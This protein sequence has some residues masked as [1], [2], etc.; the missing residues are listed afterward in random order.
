MIKKIA[1]IGNGG[2]AK[3]LT[4]YINDCNTPFKKP[5]E[6][7]T[8]I[9]NDDSGARPVEELISNIDRYVVYIGI[10]SGAVRKRIVEEILPVNTVYGTLVHPT[11]YIGSNIHIGEGSIVCPNCVIT[12]NVKIG[13]HVQLNIQTS[14][15]HDSELSDYVTTSPKVSI[16]GDN[17]VGECAYL[18]TSTSTKEKINI[19]SDVVLGLNS[20]V[21]KDIFLSGT[22][23]GTPAKKIR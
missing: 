12:S 16:S 3:E 15:G 2:F 17:Y 19:C 20:G 13:K 9:E 18:G 23:V 22:Y 6:Y 10:G 1:I 5:L 11:A 4:T 21:V 8:T 14:I 7:F